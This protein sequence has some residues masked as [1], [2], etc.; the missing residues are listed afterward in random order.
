MSVQ[1]PLAVA[2]VNVNPTWQI[3]YMA[4]EQTSLVPEIITVAVD[5]ADLLASGQNKFKMYYVVL[6]NGLYVTKSS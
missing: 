6:E 3:D 4:V 2:P 5:V 1:T